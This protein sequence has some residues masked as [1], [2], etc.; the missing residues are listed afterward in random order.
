MNKVA[1][2]WILPL[3]PALLTAFLRGLQ[4]STCVLFSLVLRLSV[5]GARSAKS[6]VLDLLPATS[7]YRLSLSAAS[8]SE[9]PRRDCNP[10]HLTLTM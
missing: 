1:L 9:E 2:Y 10:R 7:D 6:N 3:E 5:D 4:S 8:G